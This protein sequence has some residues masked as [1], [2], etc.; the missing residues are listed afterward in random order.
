MTD[1]PKL[2]HFNKRDANELPVLN[3]RKQAALLESYALLFDMIYNIKDHEE[4][5]RQANIE[6][7]Y[8]ERDCLGVKHQPDD[9]PAGAE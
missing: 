1:K 6:A 2:I 5:K 4:L 7:Y 3:R 9:I 8:M